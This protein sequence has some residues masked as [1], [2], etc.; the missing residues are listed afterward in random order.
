L[1]TFLGQAKKV[2]RQQGERVCVDELV[3]KDGRIAF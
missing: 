3:L 2:T 1:V